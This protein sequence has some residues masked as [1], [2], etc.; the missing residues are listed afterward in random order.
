MLGKRRAGTYGEKKSQKNKPNKKPGD[1]PW[2]RSFLF[3]FR[4]FFAFIFTVFPLFFCYFPPSSQGPLSRM[5]GVWERRTRRRFIMSPC[6][7]DF[8]EDR[9]MWSDSVELWAALRP[10]R[11]VIGGKG[12]YRPQS[13]CM[14]AVLLSTKVEVPAGR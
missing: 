8:D 3:F 1:C 10:C 12:R 14:R 6:S 5:G 9:L 13:F 2:P 11:R 7:F 4:F